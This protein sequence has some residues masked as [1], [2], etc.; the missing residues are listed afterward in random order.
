M[1]VC[2]RARALAITAQ[3]V[4]TREREKYSFGRRVR[5]T[6]ATHRRRRRRRRLLSCS[7]ADGV[8]SAVTYDDLSLSLS[9]FL[10]DGLVAVLPCVCAFV[11]DDVCSCVYGAAVLREC[12]RLFQESHRETER[13]R[14]D[15]FEKRRR[16][17]QLIIHICICIYRYV[18]HIYILY[19]MIYIWMGLHSR[20]ILNRC[21]LCVLCFNQTKF[22]FVQRVR[23]SPFIQ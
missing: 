23:L 3:R 8:R 18:I 15:S 16:F 12:L 11:C 20:V 7:G 5:D 2:S 4:C 17:A 10:A 19:D 22:V 6:F 9:V 13:E 21:A 14:P 1:C